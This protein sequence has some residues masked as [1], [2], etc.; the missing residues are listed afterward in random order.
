MS[1]WLNVALAI[2]VLGSFVLIIGGIIALRKGGDQRK[3]GGLMIA[4]AVI[5]LV[6]VFIL[7]GAAVHPVD[8]PAPS[9]AEEK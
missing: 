9:V 6:N 3:R 2:G 1:G 5:T 4:V 8:D 7:S